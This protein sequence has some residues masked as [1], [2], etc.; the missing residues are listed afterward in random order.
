MT[1][2]GTI[3][4]IARRAT[5]TETGFDAK[6]GFQVIFV[7][8]KDL[9][10]TISVDTAVKYGLFHMEPDGSSFTIGDVEG[11]KVQVECQ[12]HDSTCE[13]VSVKKLEGAQSR[14]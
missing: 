5:I 9:D 14:K 10:F 7:D 13:I 2:T 11:W 6:A 4:F 8:Q 1:H 3:R 12:K